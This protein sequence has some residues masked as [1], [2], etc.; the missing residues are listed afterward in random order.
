MTFVLIFTNALCQIEA[1]LG[2]FVVFVASFVQ[3]FSYWI[4]FSCI[5]HLPSFQ[6]LVNF[7]SYNIFCRLSNLVVS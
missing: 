4:A 1:A 5:F 3:N 6:H 2:I 7:V